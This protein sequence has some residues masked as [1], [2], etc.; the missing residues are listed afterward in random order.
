MAMKRIALWSVVPGLLVVLALL[1]V[2]AVGA[3]ANEETEFGNHNLQGVYEF[4]AD[5]V[6]EVNEVYTR[7]T[8]EVGRFV[9]DGNGN[10]TDGVEYSSLLSSS[11][12]SIIDLNFT[13]TGT[14]EVNPDGTGTAQITV[15][16]PTGDEIEKSLWFVIYGVGKKGIAN[17]FAGGHA[18]ADLG[19]GVHGNSRTHVGTRVEIAK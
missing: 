10:W 1:I 17:G 19:G 2:A 9:A 6:V 14:Y 16:L 18:D 12:E 15:V 11:D 7:G 3:Q 5:G 13:F 8:W 4:H